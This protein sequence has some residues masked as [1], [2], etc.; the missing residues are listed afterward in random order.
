MPIEDDVGVP[1]ETPRKTTMAII[2]T[3]SD[4]EPDHRSRHTFF[5]CS[6]SGSMPETGR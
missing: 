1:E 3:V 5:N 6:A 2:E 4:E